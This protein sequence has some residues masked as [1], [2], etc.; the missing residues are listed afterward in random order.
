MNRAALA[1]MHDAAMHHGL[2]RVCEAFTVTH[3]VGLGPFL[4]QHIIATAIFPTCVA[5]AGSKIGKWQRLLLL[6]KMSEGRAFAVHG[7]K[8]AVQH[9]H[10]SPCDSFFGERKAGAARAIDVGDC[11]HI[12][13]KVEDW[14]DFYDVHEYLSQ[15]PPLN[16]SHD[17]SRSCKGLL[18]YVAGDGRP[19]PLVRQHLTYNDTAHARRYRETGIWAP[20]TPDHC[21]EGPAGLASGRTAR[22]ARDMVV[23]GKQRRRRRL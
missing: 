8:E 14:V 3:D 23:K 13:H 16:L 9:G 21:K 15:R 19:P 5:I 4:W 12:L 18:P 10:T 22:A 7:A 20:F 17:R 2:Q 1:A 11:Q 6:L